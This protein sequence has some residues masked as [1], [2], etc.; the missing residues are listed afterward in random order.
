MR[1]TAPV[2]GEPPANRHNWLSAGCRAPAVQPCSHAW[3]ACN[4]QQLLYCCCLPVIQS[5]RHCSWQVH[6]AGSNLYSV[7]VRRRLS[8]MQI[9]P[10]QIQRYSAARPSL[11]RRGSTL[12][13]CCIHVP[14]TA[15]ISS[16][17]VCCRC[18]SACCAHHVPGNHNGMH[19]NNPHCIGVQTTAHHIP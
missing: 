17:E 6:T 7:Q 8:P 14:P 5:S 4:R 18:P 15:I 3:P 19:H 11:W 1:S 16:D 10:L 2:R 13:C 9:L 12:W